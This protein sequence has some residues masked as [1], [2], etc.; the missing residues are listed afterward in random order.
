MGDTDSACIGMSKKRRLD[1][2]EGREGMET[3]PRW[4]QKK[5]GCVAVKLGR[6][7]S[8]P[9]VCKA[10]PGLYLPAACRTC[11][12]EWGWGFSPAL[13]AL[14]LPVAACLQHLQ[15]SRCWTP[16]PEQD[17]N[18]PSTASEQFLKLQV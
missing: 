5:C 16:Q 2:G 7:R 8:R 12:T 11:H 17:R 4:E 1:K 14:S 15:R 6:Q 3:L 18:W 10:N 9:E 13:P